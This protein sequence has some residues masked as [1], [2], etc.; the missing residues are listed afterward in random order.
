M[1]F[2]DGF[3]SGDTRCW[4]MKMTALLIPYKEQSLAALS[5]LEQK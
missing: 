4:D 5:W 3:E 1:I 2:S